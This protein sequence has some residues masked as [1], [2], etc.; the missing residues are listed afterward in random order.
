MDYSWNEE[1]NELYE[2]VIE[3]AESLN[4]TVG[5]RDRRHQFG[6][7][8]WRRCGEF[9]LHGLC[10]PK[11][12]GGLGLS[13]LTTARLLEGFGYGCLDMGL[14]FSSAAHLFACAVPVWDHGS[15]ALQDRYL[16][17]LATGSMVGANAITEDTAG[18]DVF[19]M[20][21]TA[22]PDGET[23]V[24]NGSKAYVTNG[25]VADLFLVYASTNPD[26]GFLGISAFLVE[27][28]RDGLRVG[29]PY[30]KIGL[31]TSP[32][33]AIYLDDCTVPARNRLGTEGTGGQIF[34]ESMLWERGCLFGGYLGAMRRQ[35]ENSVEFAKEREQFGEPIGSFQGISH[36]IADMKLRLD[37][38]RLLLYRACWLRD[39]NEQ[40]NL[41]TALAKLAVSESAIQSGLDTIQVHGGMG[42]TKEFTAERE[43]RNAV[44]STLF[45]GTSEIQRNIVA[46][47]LGL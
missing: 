30:E 36:K 46:R 27:R 1:Q 47:E 7:E 38:A 9:G 19:S 2:R 42:V 40:A 18:S 28:D 31:T 21:S 15:E 23:Y 13:A 17:E 24:L 35:L 29:E 14:V 26:H 45:S 20:Q 43:L 25:P 22:K 6:A 12:Y 37:S 44:P 34:K 4:E 11:Q 39:N 32:M 16:K 3:F 5:E 33:S 8:E 41:E 10:L